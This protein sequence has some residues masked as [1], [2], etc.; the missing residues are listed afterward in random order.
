[1]AAGWSFQH[2]QVSGRG[3]RGWR[4]ESPEAR[5]G[6][7]LGSGVAGLLGLVS[8]RERRATLRATCAEA[9]AGNHVGLEGPHLPLRTAGDQLLASFVDGE[10]EQRG[11]W[12]MKQTQVTFTS[13]C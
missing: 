10:A 3:Q 6:R 13:T 9:P 4:E 12:W 2:T 7:R 1:M 8:R 11:R 5:P